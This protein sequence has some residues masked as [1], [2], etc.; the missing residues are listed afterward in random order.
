MESK[1]DLQDIPARLYMDSPGIEWRYGLPDYSVVNK[2]FLAERTK[3]HKEGSLEKVVEDLVKTWEMET[4]NKLNPKDWVTVDQDNF[5]VRVN[6]GEKFTKDDY[7][8]DGNYNLMLRN[9]PLYD[10]GKHSFDSSQ[11][12]F[13]GVFKSGFAWEV[14]DVFSGPPTVAFTWRHWGN[15]EGQYKQ[16]PATG[17]TIEMFGCCVAKV[18]DQLKI[19][20]VD[21]YFD[22]N[23]MMATFTGCT[24]GKICP[25]SH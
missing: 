12:L 23:I 7:V 17:E 24:G 11:D 5:F 20:S 19:Q 25:L 22:P 10:A 18:T 1:T 15:F 8:K 3:V 16:T 6:G 9:C 14:L 13:R 4:G 21:V 2:K